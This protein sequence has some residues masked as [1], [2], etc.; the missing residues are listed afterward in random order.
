M[1]NFLAIS[2][3]VILGLGVICLLIFL[4]ITMAIVLRGKR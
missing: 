3:F 1:D 4:A 2:S